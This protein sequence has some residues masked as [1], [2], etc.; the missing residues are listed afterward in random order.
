VTNGVT[1]LARACSIT[2]ARPSS[3][4]SPKRPP[5]SGCVD[6][7]ALLSADDDRVALRANECAKRRESTALE[8]R[9]AAHSR[10]EE[11]KLERETGDEPPSTNHPVQFVYR[12]G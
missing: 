8:S 3:L 4:P 11:T 9:S 2:Q 5:P 10:A 6:A 12:L 7:I 1:A